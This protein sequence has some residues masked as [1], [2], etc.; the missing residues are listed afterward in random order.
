[1]RPLMIM[2]LAVFFAG[3]A[4]AATAG[5]QSDA[6][7]FPE[8]GY[9]ISGSIRQ[10]WERNGG[11]AVFGYPTGPVE[12]MTI[13]GWTGPAQWFQRDRLEDHANQGLGVLAGRLGA[14]RLAQLGRPWVP[15]GG[16]INLT[17]NCR[18]FPETGYNMCGAFRSYWESN[19][20]LERFGYP[21]TTEFTEIIEG[22]P[23]TVQYFERRRMEWHPENQ[24]PFNVLLGLLGNEVRGNVPTACSVSV[25]NEFQYNYR[26]FGG[27][28]RLGC[29]IPGQDY[30]FTQAAAARFE[31]GQMYWV[32]LRGGRSIVV[33]LFYEANNRISYQIFE[34]FWREG[35]PVNTGLT[36]PAGLYEPQRGFGKVWR[37]QPGVRERLGWAL[38]TERQ[39]Y[40]SYQVFERGSLLLISSESSVWELA[41]DGQA[42][43]DPQRWS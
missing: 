25:L 2:L 23:Y 3:L 31:R 10:Y 42:R 6:R 12:T 30:S 34:D 5:A 22:K 20:G 43:R 18:H 9:C 19:G 14:E 17:P 32:N 37:E 13:E 11:L 41:P 39:E 21:I 28:G 1:M 40:A 27:Q 29:P 24:P 4:P 7:C 36:P 15:G 38:E 26:D 35:D 33:V 16:G 8:T